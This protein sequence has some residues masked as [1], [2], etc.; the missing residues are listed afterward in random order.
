MASSAEVVSVLLRAGAQIAARH[1]SGP[2]FGRGW[3]PLHFACQRRKVGVISE[4][5]RAGAGTEIRDDVSA[6]GSVTCDV[7]NA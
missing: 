2:M 5:L 3:T 4:L 7:I 1:G 6:L